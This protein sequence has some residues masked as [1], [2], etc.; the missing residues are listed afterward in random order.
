VADVHGAGQVGEIDTITAGCGART[1]RGGRYCRCEDQLLNRLAR[2]GNNRFARWLADDSFPPRPPDLAVYRHKGMI[3]IGPPFLAVVLA[4]GL[5]IL[6]TDFGTAVGGYVLAPVFMWVASAMMWLN[7]VTTAVR[8]QAD[9]LVLD[10]WL[11]RHV[12]PWERFAGLFVENGVGMFARLDDGTV[13][14]SAAYARSLSDA[15]QGYRHMRE[16]LDRI[17]DDCR[18]ARTGRAVAGPAP[19]YRRM[20]NLPWRP[21]A[22]VLVFFEAFAWITFAMHSA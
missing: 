12:I 1:R 20:V 17:R 18:Q 11:V 19:P 8:V 22:L 10:N 16:T 2:I 6:A 13:V 4:V 9:C 15:M 3:W 21:L 7:T 14:K 5:P